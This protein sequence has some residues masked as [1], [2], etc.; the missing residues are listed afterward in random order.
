MST[1][2][3]ARP[4]PTTALHPGDRRVRTLGVL[5]LVAGLLLLL[6]GAG[7]AVAIR[8]QLAAERIVISEDAALFGGEQLDTPV[9]AFVQAEAIRGHAAGIA[10]GRTYAQLDRDDPVRA[11]IAETAFLR[12]SLLT[13]V[14]A[15]GVAGLTAGL[16]VLFVVVGV[17]LRRVGRPHPIEVSPLDAGAAPA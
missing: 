14:T 11:T 6:A 15:S 8:D 16:G 13:S 9:D 4:A 12:A 3:D 2:T 10:D 7:A 5:T 17:A 1:S